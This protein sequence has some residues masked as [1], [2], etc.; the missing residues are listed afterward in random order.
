[1]RRITNTNFCS[2]AVIAAV[3]SA[4]CFAGDEQTVS[5]EME[6]RTSNTIRME[7][8]AGGCQA[9]L[10]LDYWQKGHLAEVQAT[11]NNEECAASQGDF[12]LHVTYRD[13]DGAVTTDEHPESWAR[14]DDQAVEISREYEIGHGV[15]LVRVRSRGLSCSCSA[16][17][18]ASPGEAAPDSESP[19]D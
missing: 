17:E 7:M 9:N 4:P 18:A 16:T 13:S 6:I 1:M 8:H 19:E 15:D 5:T 12:A 14:D 10:A 11:V 3:T 2:L